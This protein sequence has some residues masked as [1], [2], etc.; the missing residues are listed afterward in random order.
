MIGLRNDVTRD[1][2]GRDSGRLGGR[3]DRRQGEVDEW[4]FL[5]SWGSVQ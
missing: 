2:R 4:R 3:T 1:A 5:T